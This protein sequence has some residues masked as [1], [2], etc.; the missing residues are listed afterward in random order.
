MRVNNRIVLTE[1]WLSVF[2]WSYVPLL[3]SGVTGSLEI[4][5]NYFWLAPTIRA[6]D[7]LRFWKEFVRQLIC[8]VGIKWLSLFFT[9]FNID[10]VF[11]LEVFLLILLDFYTLW[12]S[13]HLDHPFPSFISS[14]RY[15]I[16]KVHHFLYSFP[17]IICIPTAFA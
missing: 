10:T 3:Y 8:E 14:M 2:W 7:P 4:T 17:E 6:I 15:G 16:V 12:F 9:L 13:C 5:V 1:Y 11:L